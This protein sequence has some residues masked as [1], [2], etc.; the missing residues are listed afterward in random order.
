MGFEMLHAWNR[1]S[2]SRLEVEMVLVEIAPFA[3]VAI[4]AAGTPEL[5]S[6]SADDIGLPYWPATRC[7]RSCNI[8]MVDGGFH[9]IQK[10][11]NG[12][13]DPGCGS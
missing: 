4:E 10:E 11:W 9:P 3:R 1:V 5:A 6:A 8:A 12:N 2:E 13:R 7:A